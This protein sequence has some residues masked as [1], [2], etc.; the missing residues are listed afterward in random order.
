MKDG[1]TNELLVFEDD[2]RWVSENLESLLD[3]YPDSG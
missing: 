3:Q 1:L 2:H